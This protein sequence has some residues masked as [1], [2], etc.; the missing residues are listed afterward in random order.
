MWMLIIG[1]CGTSRPALEA[2]R[3]W[4]R[5]TFQEF[6]KSKASPIPIPDCVAGSTALDSSQKRLSCLPFIQNHTVFLRAENCFLHCGPHRNGVPRKTT[7]I[8]DLDARP[9][10]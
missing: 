10:S 9:T 5:P 2:L 7:V 3:R 4:S 8:L 1:F 6:S